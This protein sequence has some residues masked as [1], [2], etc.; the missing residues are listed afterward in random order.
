MNTLLMSVDFEDWHQIVHRRLGLADWHR[1]GPALQRQSR[2][3]LDMLDRMGVRATFFILG[4]TADAYPREVEEIA[5]RGHEIASHGYAH[6]RVFDQSPDEFH[7]DIAKSVEV[8]EGITGVRPVGYRAPAFSINRRTVWAYEVL[9]DLGFLWDSSQND[10]PRI[11][12][13]IQGIPDTPYAFTEPSGAEMWEFPLAIAQVRG[14]AVP[15]AG[16][17]YWRVLPRRTVASALRGRAPGASGAL[18][19]HPYELGS[20][21]LRADLPPGASARLRL[22]GLA[23]SLKANP[24]RRRVAKCLRYLARDFR[25][26]TYGEAFD[27]YQRHGQRP[28]SL[29]REGSIV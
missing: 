12:N 22:N 11:P 25:L 16:G 28:R 2:E 24:G 15:V 13:R 6:Y 18:Y 27:E 9:A 23:R 19:T 26:T 7:A 17:S 1:P 14:R 20:R 10:S 29:S 5:A 3:T 8:I 4:M 21:A